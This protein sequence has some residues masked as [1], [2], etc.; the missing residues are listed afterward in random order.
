[1]RAK[2]EGGRG[3][4]RGSGDGD[5]EEKAR[6]PIGK[7]VPFFVREFDAVYSGGGESDGVAEV[8]NAYV[9]AFRS[10]EDVREYCRMVAAI[11]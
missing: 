4:G 1:M 10:S 9:Q 8:E 7:L 6:V 2:I 5:G 3:G 11:D